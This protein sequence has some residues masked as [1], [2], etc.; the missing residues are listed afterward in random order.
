MAVVKDSDLLCERAVAEHWR[1]VFRFL[2]AWTNDWS[3]AEDLTQEAFLRLWKCRD[4][5]DWS[6]PILPWLFLTGRRLA[7]DRYRRLA[8]RLAGPRGEPALD[9]TSRAEWLD[10][11]EALRLLSPIER[12]AVVLTLFVGMPTAESAEI[13]NTTSGAVRAAVSRARGKLEGAR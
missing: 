1:D 5:I 13:L 2:L 7:T 8:R 11:Q 9:E 10:V 12:T 4:G 3:A 6:R